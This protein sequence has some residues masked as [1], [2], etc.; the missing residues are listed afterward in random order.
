MDTA[1]GMEIEEV[2]R[3]GGRKKH[4]ATNGQLVRTEN[5]RYIYAFTLEDAWEV[6]D[7]TPVQIESTG[8][9]ANAY[10]VAAAG[11]SIKIAADWEIP[12]RDLARLTL[13]DDPT[14]ILTA[15]RKALGEAQDGPNELVARTF[16]IQKIARTQPIALQPTRGLC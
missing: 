3:R 7:D 4:N 14:A 6:A 15:L 9:G 13:K 2:N 16:G 1:I 5:G 11:R 12:A 8:K 10:V